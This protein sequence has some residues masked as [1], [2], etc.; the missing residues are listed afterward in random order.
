MMESC[1]CIDTQ[2]PPDELLVKYQYI[3][4]VL[5]ALAYFS[6][7]VELIYFVQKS[8]FFPYRWVL[9]QFGAF[10]VLCGATHFINL[11]TF[12]PHSKAVAVVMTIAKVSCAIVSCATAL[13]LVHI[14]PDLLSVK[15]REL[16]LKNKA[17]ELDREMGL[18]LTQEETGRHVRML[19]HEIRSTLDRHTILKTTL[20]E[21]GRT[22][23][24]EECALWMPSRNGLNLQLSHTLT[25]HVQVGST[26]QTNN[27]IVNE[28]FNSPRAMRIP[29]TCPLARIRP[30]VGRYVPPE[31]VAVRVPLLNLSNFQINDWPDISAKS[32]AIMVLI[33]PTDS[34]RKWR[35][36]EL[37][38]VDVV[39]DQVAVALSH[40]AILEE[41]MR[42][43]DQL[44]EQNVALDLARREA[45]MAIHAR[46][47]FLAVMNH[48]M[49]T[50]MHAIIALSSLLLETELTPE[51]RVMIETVLKSSNVLATLINDVLDL[52]RLEDGS[53]ELEMGKLNLHAV[54]GEI[55]E[56]I[57]PIASVKKLPITL[58]LAPD[59]P[60]HAIGDEKRLTQTLLNVV[61]NAVKFTKEGYVSI[62]ASVA[63]PESLQDWRPP[64]FY[65]TSSDGHFYIRVQV[66][67]SGCGIP[68]QD[69]PHLFTKFAQSRSGPARPSSGAGLG[70]AIC[71]RFVNLMGGHIWIESEGPGKGSTATF[72]VKLGICGNPDPSDHQ[73]TNRSQAYS[74]SGGLARFKPFIKDEDDSGFST[75]RNQRSF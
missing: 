74:G 72:I 58:I 10:I 6:I 70:L 24:L 51:Q 46:N 32:Y 41:S 19:T 63:K 29:P 28:V 39:A 18:I 67:D 16:F 15:T 69:I 52:S 2:Y 55:V 73:A 59:L 61:G 14:I 38:L 35:D 48:E 25:Y 56:L 45:E 23:G 21:L 27:P 60:A 20:V 7:P 71:K 11:W 42:A 3:S 43:R 53:L 37:E 12:S 17:E 13:M 49:R 57:K 40:A 66:K 44:M 1:D 8:A 54:L 62:R 36:H 31:V 33:L 75:R 34:V 4:D 9:M 64:E 68:P 65:P 50:P 26:V 30:L 22:L 47:D 5:I